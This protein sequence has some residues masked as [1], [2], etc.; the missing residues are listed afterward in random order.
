M[1]AFSKGQRVNIDK[2]RF[3]Y[4]CLRTFGESPGDWTGF[5]STD[6]PRL[7]TLAS[8]PTEGVINGY[9]EHSVTNMAILKDVRVG[10][11]EVRLAMPD[12]GFKWIWISAKFL[13]PCFKLA[14]IPKQGSR[15]TDQKI[16]AILLG[17]CSLSPAAKIWLHNSCDRLSK[18]M[19][20]DNNPTLRDECKA[21]G[22]IV[23]D[24][25][26]IGVDSLVMDLVQK[27]GIISGEVQ[28]SD[29]QIHTVH[30]ISSSTG[31]K[32]FEDSDKASAIAVAMRFVTELCSVES[33]PHVT[34]L[35]ESRFGTT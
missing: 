24:K 15:S 12:G 4:Y 5:P 14:R 29:K 34:I 21:A 16:G 1:T 30:I 19:M 27:K 11:Y 8:M 20:C 7:D 31:R 35:V 10:H 3:I 32:S 33:S 9:R 26:G 25:N 2:A 18:G 28:Q 6:F 13:S 17:L 22:L 23:A